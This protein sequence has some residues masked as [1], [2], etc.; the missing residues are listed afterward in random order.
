MCELL[1][2]LIDNH[3]P[4]PVKD[5]RACYK[6][7]DVVVVKPD[8]HEWGKKECPPDFEVVKIPGAKME[9]YLHLIF[10]K[11]DAKGEMSARRYYKYD[12]DKRAV[13]TR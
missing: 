7:G 1:V 3:H 5:A 11:T 4:D 13:V 2:R 9:D 12:L 6:R 10:P 8:E